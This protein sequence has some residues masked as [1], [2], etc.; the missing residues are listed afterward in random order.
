M[1]RQNRM[2]CTFSISS[3]LKVSVDQFWESQSLATVNAELFPLYRMSAP[4]D[5]LH[6]PIQQWSD[7]SDQLKS[8][9][10][11]L[12]IIP[13]D[14]HSFG[15]IKFTGPTTF[16]ETSSSWLNS[17]WLHERIVTQVPHGCEV[18]DNVAFEPRIRTLASLQ[19]GLYRRAFCHRHE[20]LRNRYTAS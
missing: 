10:Y 4:R 12:G 20:V 18:K 7:A 11:F 16:L 1:D 8:W 5:W 9:I 13:V 3:S 17:S 14:R 2:L 15:T 19:K 6:L